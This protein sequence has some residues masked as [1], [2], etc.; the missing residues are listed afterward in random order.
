MV[1]PVSKQYID[2]AVKVKDSIHAAGFY[3]DV[4]L[5]QRTLN[6]MVRAT[7]LAQCNLALPLPYRCLTVAIPLPCLHLAFTLPSPCL[8]LAVTYRLIWNCHHRTVTVRGRDSS[9]FVP[10]RA[11]T[12]QVR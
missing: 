5:S 1:V 11:A 2:Y 10:S 6:K 8:H 3:V 7:Q 12:P 9:R 4:E